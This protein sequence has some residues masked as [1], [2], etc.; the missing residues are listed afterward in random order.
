MKLENDL[1]RIDVTTCGGSLTS[2]YD[3]KRNVEL[4][5]QPHEDSWQGQDIFIFPFI[6][7]LKNGYYL[8]NDKRYDLKNHGLIRYMVGEDSS[9]KDNIK[10]SFKSDD[11]TLVRFPF[12]FEASITYTLVNNEIIISYDIFNTGENPLPFE[13]GAHPAFK[14][15]GVKRNDEFDISG[16]YIKFDG[17]KKLKL[18]EE[19]ETASFVLD[20]IDYL[21]TDVILLNKKLFNDINTIILKADDINEVTL[22][23]RDGSSLTL[24]INNATYL[25]L[26]SD[27]KRGDYVCIEP[28]LGLP[29]YNEPEREIYKKPHMI[30]LEKGKHFT[31][32]YK[33]KIS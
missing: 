12:D 25:A 19:E 4:L 28:W 31:Y 17:V 27:K 16:N 3:K 21:E 32:S 7:R 30:L 15:P 20:E 18:V 22:K 24:E 11:K 5:Y 14:L 13:L 2:I 23:K 6:A 26:W 10:V 33:I 29:D 9:S 8:H 1:I